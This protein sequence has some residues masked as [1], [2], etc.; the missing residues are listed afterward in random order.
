MFNSA[1]LITFSSLRSK[2][3]S[4]SEVLC[5]ACERRFWSW[6]AKRFPTEVLYTLASNSYIMVLDFAFDR[7]EGNEG[8]ERRER[9]C[10]FLRKV[11]EPAVSLPEVAKQHDVSV[12]A[13][14]SRVLVSARVRFRFGNSSSAATVI[15]QN[16]HLFPLP[17]TVLVSTLS[18]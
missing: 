10:H 11:T 13:I 4:A 15:Y 2:R 8:N 17:P 9:E 1:S 3:S 7:C 12:R 18:K 14:A 6:E 16:W 5:A